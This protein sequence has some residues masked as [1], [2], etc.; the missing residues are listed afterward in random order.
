MEYPLTLDYEIFSIMK[1]KI[2]YFVEEYITYLGKSS[3]Y[4]SL[5]NKCSRPEN[6]YDH[7]S[8]LHYILWLIS[9][10][11]KKKSYCCLSDSFLV[12][13]RIHFLVYKFQ[14]VGS[15]P[16]FF[17]HF[18]NLSKTQPQNIKHFFRAIRLP[19]VRISNLFTAY[20]ANSNLYTIG[21]RKLLLSFIWNT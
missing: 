3:T 20:Q 17:K 12:F 13:T 18:N 10:S 15:S 6:F 19:S 9:N 2:S 5:F 1:G 21:Y 14:N 16:W 11:L 8:M 7:F 4:M